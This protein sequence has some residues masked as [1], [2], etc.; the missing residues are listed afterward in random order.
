M[1]SFV[2][3]AFPIYLQHVLHCIVNLQH[4]QMQLSVNKMAVKRR[5][6]FC[7]GDQTKPNFFDV[8]L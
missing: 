7:I 4:K 5:S 1:E 2:R 8:L 3:S 6:T